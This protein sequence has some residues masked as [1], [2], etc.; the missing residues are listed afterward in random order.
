[1]Y[2]SQELAVRVV[3]GLGDGAAGRDGGGVYNTREY[4]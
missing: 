2:I 4:V 1:M 3:L